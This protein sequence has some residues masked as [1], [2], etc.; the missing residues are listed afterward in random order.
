MLNFGNGSAAVGPTPDAIKDVS[1]ATFMADV[2]EASMEVPVIVD[3]WAP[4]CGPCKQLTP[5]LEAAV[6]DSGG[7]VRLA[8][9]NVDENQRIA[10]QMRVQSIPAVFGFVGGRPVD[11]FMG[12]QGPAQIREFVKRLV[13]MAPATDQLNEVLDAADQLLAEG[14]VAEAAQTYGAIL[15]EDKANIRAIAGL[16]RVHLAVG[17]VEKAKAV[18]AMAPAGTKDAQLTAVQ[19]QIDLAE[20]SADAGESGALRRQVEAEPGNLQA[21]FDLAMA[22]VA[23]RDHQGAIDEL[24]EIFRRD[25]EWND[26]AAKEQLIKL[27]DSLGPKDPIGQKGRRRLSS[28]VFA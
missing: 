2:I 3:F 22:L 18:L 10:A 26:G 20:I 6:R 21:R 25:R 8:K 12:A 28:M 17:D 11:G 15:T 16:A 9:V 24:L 5:V 19:A 14:A 23:Q 27:F 4:W 7:K 1:E 13:S